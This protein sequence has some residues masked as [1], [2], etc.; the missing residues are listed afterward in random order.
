MLLADLKQRSNEIVICVLKDHV[1]SYLE[2]GLDRADMEPRRLRNP[3]ENR[4]ELGWWPL[5]QTGTD[6]SASKICRV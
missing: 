5:N 2:N 6:L 3:G 4:S 1:G